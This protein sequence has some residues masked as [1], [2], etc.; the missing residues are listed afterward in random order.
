MWRNSYI[1]KG[2]LVAGVGFD[3]FKFYKARLEHKIQT[4]K[5]YICFLILG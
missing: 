5:L 2:I 3:N 1:L 4:L